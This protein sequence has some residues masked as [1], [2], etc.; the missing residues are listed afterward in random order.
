[1]R[2]TLLVVSFALAL[3]VSPL[4]LL[5]QSQAP[6]L[7]A[8]A[9]GGAIAPGTGATA[10]GF[11]A[12]GL[13]FQSSVFGQDSIAND[14]NDTIF[15]TQNVA[16]TGGTLTN[17]LA[18]ATV[19]GN[20]NNTLASGSFVAGSENTASAAASNS[21]LIGTSVTSNAANEILAGQGASGNGP[22]QIIM[23]T[24]A[25]G[26]NQATCSAIGFLANCNQSGTFSVGNDGSTDGGVPLYAR[27]VNVAPGINPNDAMILQ[28]GSGL[29][30]A[31]GGGAAFDSAGAFVAPT[32][33]L[34]TQNFNNVGGALSYLYSLDSGT[35]TPP[36]P[37]T[38]GGGGGSSTDPN[39]VHYDDGT[40]ATI[41]L[42]GANGTTISNVAPGAV[43]S[44]STD[45]I[46]GGQLY[47][48]E[49]AGQAYTN[50][51][52]QAGVGQAENWAKTYTDQQIAGLNNRLNRVGAASMASAQMAAS[53]AGQDP[54][55]HNRL[56]VGVGSQGGDG[57]LS[58]GYQHVAAGGHLAWNI[59]ATIS[60]PERSIGAGLSYGW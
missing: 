30:S 48:S 52:V 5:A 1:M 50:Q 12:Q 13:G 2:R 20:N 33:S 8:Y 47:Q 10:I 58:V 39:A 25:S 14:F 9:A 26:T 45:A 24:S 51:Q 36:P 46:N 43:T 60:G 6:G 27:I 42:G 11:A 23:G 3:L 7:N 40:K 18:G 28:Q 57:A 31:L 22:D 54:N 34:G 16:A 49:Q 44:T 38:S 32:Y 53:F 17:G 55:N 15:G 59:G 37:P 19:I 4:T 56:A 29:A 21:I 41:T 35:P